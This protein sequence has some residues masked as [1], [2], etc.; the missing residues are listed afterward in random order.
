MPVI[1]YADTPARLRNLKQ[2]TSRLFSNGV[3]YQALKDANQHLVTLQTGP[4]IT[5]K[6]QGLIKLLEFNNP[7]Q[8]FASVVASVALVIEK[9]NW[10]THTAKIGDILQAIEGS[11]YV[12]IHHSGSG[13]AV[14]RFR[15]HPHPHLRGKGF[16]IAT[17]S[18][19]P[20]GGVVRVGSGNLLYSKLYGHAGR[21]TMKAGGDAL[22]NGIINLGFNVHVVGPIVTKLLGATGLITGAEAGTLLRTF[23]LARKTAPA[24]TSKND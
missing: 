15:P 11:S 9:L 7:K 3:R 20:A 6:I 10:Q 19:L 8:H 24:I 22:I 23:S 16:I 17:G 4:H 14:T 18:G 1:I 13:F 2:I 21:R 5:V 12:L